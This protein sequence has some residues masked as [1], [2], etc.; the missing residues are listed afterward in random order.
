MKDTIQKD[1]RRSISYIN[2]T[3]YHG[4]WELSYKYSKILMKNINNYNLYEI[5]LIIHNQ[6]MNE[7]KH[8]K[9]NKDKNKNYVQVWETM[10]NTVFKG[11]DNS[12][13]AVR[14][15]HQTNQKRTN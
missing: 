3:K 8:K 7:L 9:I 13:G 10:L 4:G 11:K 12:K 2:Q 1:Y 14:L 5:C 15:L 6:Y